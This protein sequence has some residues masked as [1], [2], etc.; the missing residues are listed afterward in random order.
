MAAAAVAALTGCAGADPNAVGASEASA[1]TIYS[2]LPL[3]GPDAAISASIVNGE[4]LALADAGGRVGR[5]HVSLVSLDDADPASGA[6]SPGVTSTAAR[7]ASQDKS[8]IAYIGDYD[9][10]ATAISLPLVNEAGILQ[11]SPGSP[12]VGLT[13][14]LDAG[15]GEPARYYPTGTQ[16]FVRLGPDDALQARAQL[17]Y[18]RELGVRN[19]LVLGDSDVFSS[20]IAA[21]VAREAPR[22]R[23]NI[24]GNSAVD[25]TTD[26]ASIVAKLHTTGA[27]ALLLAGDPS[28]T[29][30]SIWQAVAAADPSLK[31][32]APSELA[33]PAF[34]QALGA[35]EKRTYVTSPVLP[36]DWYPAAARRFARD[37]EAQFH[38]RPDAYALYGYEAVSATLAAIRSAGVHGADRNAVRRA[39]FATQNRNSVLG[40]YSVTSKGATTLSSFAADR[41]RNGRLV[42][43]HVIDVGPPPTA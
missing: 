10:G 11:I 30:I 23:I 8:A 34:L 3:Q 18:M 41:V 19:L 33:T 9:S 39:Y 25:R 16:T 15:K 36:L 6:W 14:P 20:D 7:T 12:Y 4:K 5:L 28:A 42:F 31:L 40:R 26:P 24:V 38:S 21:I 37:Y 35:P 29:A 22:E 17:A 43:D 2:S 13:S 32:F 1:L 27:D